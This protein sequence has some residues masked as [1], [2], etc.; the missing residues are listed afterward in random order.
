MDNA[1][2]PRLFHDRIG[3]EKR[4]CSIYQITR[5]TTT[6]FLAHPPGANSNSKV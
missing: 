6:P 4:N 5:L 2:E 3:E 1:P